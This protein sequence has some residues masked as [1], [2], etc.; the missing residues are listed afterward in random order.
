MVCQVNDNCYGYFSAQY[1]LFYWNNATTKTIL[2]YKCNALNM[3][4]FPFDA[5]L[6]FVS[7]R[8]ILT[9]YVHLLL[10]RTRL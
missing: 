9:G 3:V 6:D 5:L 2:K 10:R 7:V 4:I 1:L 8:N